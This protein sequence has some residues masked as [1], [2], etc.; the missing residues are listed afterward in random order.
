MARVLENTKVFSSFCNY[1]NYPRLLLRRHFLPA[2]VPGNIPYL[3]KYLIFKKK[4]Y[5]VPLPSI[6]L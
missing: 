2:V 3:K 5:I 6:I 1:P 4:L